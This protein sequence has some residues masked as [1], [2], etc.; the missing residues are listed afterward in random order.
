MNWQIVTLDDI[1]QFASDARHAIW[2]DARGCWREPKIYL[3]W[4]AGY[5]NSKFSDYHINIDGG[6]HF[7]VYDPDFS[8]ILPHTYKRNSGSI[9]IALDCCVDAT[10]D[11][12]GSTPPTNDQI[13]AMAQCIAAVADS[14]WLTIDVPHVMTHGEAADNFDGNWCHERYGPS[15]TCERWDLQYLGTDESPEFTRDFNDPSTGGNVLR[16]KAN[17]Y[18]E[19]WKGESGDG[20]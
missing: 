7:W 10:S 12:L 17:W 3:H 19:Q 2:E 5:Y 6:G 8:V 13:E 4:T 16:G 9:G 14:L 18:R 11:C 20:N 15:S 1:R